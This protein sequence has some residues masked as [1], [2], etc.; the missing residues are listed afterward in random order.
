MTK[1]YE[2][3]EIEEDT[4]VKLFNVGY[5]SF[6]SLQMMKEQDLDVLRREIKIVPGQITLLRGFIQCL[7][8]K[9]HKPIFS[10]LPDTSEQRMKHAP[11]T[12]AISEKPSLSSAIAHTP[13][14]ATGARV[15]SVPSMR[16]QEGSHQNVAHQV[17]QGKLT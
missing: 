1:W 8:C 14:H 3:Y 4:L 11:S 10:T 7:N 15:N 12:S 17:N 2:I 5:K 16:L 13:S 6:S 9:R